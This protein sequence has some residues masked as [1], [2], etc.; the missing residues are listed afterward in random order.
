LSTSPL[1]RVCSATELPQHLMG[2]LDSLGPGRKSKNGQNLQNIA[3]SPGK[4]FRRLDR[5]QSLS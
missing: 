1:P 4:A 3:R 5:A 2:D